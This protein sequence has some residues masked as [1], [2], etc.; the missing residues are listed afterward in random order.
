[1]WTFIFGLMGVALA[2]GVLI[3]LL[4]IPAFIYIQPYLY[5]RDKQKRQYN[6]PQQLESENWIKGVDTNPEAAAG[7]YFKY[8]GRNTVNAT[9]LYHSWITKKPHGITKF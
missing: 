5:W 2:I 6:I 1:M 4:F 8:L 3:G 7:A 9:K